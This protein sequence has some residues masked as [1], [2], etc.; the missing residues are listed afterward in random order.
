M[1]TNVLLALSPAALM[2]GGFAFAIH[3]WR[4]QAEH[5]DARTRDAQAASMGA[6]RAA[7]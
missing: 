2:L 5:F 7:R 6:E 4:A 3:P 1:I